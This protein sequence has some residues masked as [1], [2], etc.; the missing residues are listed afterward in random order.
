VA[1]RWAR[2]V[3]VAVWGRVVV[4]VCGAVVVAVWGRV[5][6]D[7]WGAVVV[8]TA[9]PAGLASPSRSRATPTTGTPRSCRRIGSFLLSGGAFAPRPMVDV[10]P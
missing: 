8:V 6:V 2:A 5:V 1:F 4:D 3:V 9:A 10:T 7:L